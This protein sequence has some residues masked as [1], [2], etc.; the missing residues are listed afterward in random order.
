MAETT[1]SKPRTHY[2]PDARHFRWDNSLAPALTI[3]SGDTVVIDSREGTDGQITPKS[4][5][6][7]TINLD[8][9]RVHSLNGPITVRGSEPGDVLQVEMLDLEH[10]GW[11]WTGLWPQVGVLAADFGDER[12]LKIWHVGSDGRVG[13]QAGIRVPIEPFCGVIGVAMKEHGNFTTIPPR[14]M[15]GNLDIRHL[16]K[17]STVLLPVQ[18]PGA[19]FSI[20]DGHLGQGDGEVCGTAIEGPLM[21]TV[22]LTVV[23][24]HSI[25]SVQFLTRA[26]TTSKFDGMGYFA[27]TADGPDLHE[28]VRNAVRRMIDHLGQTYSLSPVDAYFLC[29]VA[30]DLKIAVPILLDQHASLVTFHMPRNIFVDVS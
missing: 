11:G 22:R 14:S 1:M 7:D 29:S 5:V 16:C 18:V 25:P 28:N 8:W 13:L 15:G 9:G 21:V 10:R 12:A 23:K 4:T 19:L 30:G 2:L 27:T 26:P 17:G 24:G 20:G 3:D 6:Q